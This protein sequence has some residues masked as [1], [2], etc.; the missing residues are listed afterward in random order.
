MKW[1]VDQLFD[2]KVTNNLLEWTLD[3]STNSFVPAILPHW[4]AFGA[5]T[6]HCLKNR[7]MNYPILK[8]AVL[9]SA[10]Y[11]FAESSDSLSLGKRLKEK[12]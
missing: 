3:Q 4:S 10:A 6:P 11:Y 7:G 12:K 1:R 8:E 9:T 5:A 2:K